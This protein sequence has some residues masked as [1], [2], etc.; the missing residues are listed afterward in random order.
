MFFL[1]VRS[2]DELGEVVA[3]KGLPTQ[4]VTIDFESFFDCQPSEVA[5]SCV[6]LMPDGSHQN[7]D[8]FH[9][10]LAPRF[11]PHTL[12]EKESGSVGHVFRSVTGIPCKPADPSARSDWDVLFREILAFVE[13]HD[14]LGV[15]F[16]KACQ[17]EAR[18]LHFLA[19]AAGFGVNE[20]VLPLLGEC[21]DLLELLLKR[22]LCANSFNIFVKEMPFELEA[23][24][25]FHVRLN[26]VRAER[27]QEAFHCALQDARTFGEM[28]LRVRQDPARLSEID[29]AEVEK[30]RLV[31]E[32]RRLKAEEERLLPGLEWGAFRCRTSGT[33]K[34]AIGRSP[35]TAEEARQ[36]ETE[37][38]ITMVVTAD[39][40]VDLLLH[41]DVGIRQVCSFICLLVSE[42]DCGEKVRAFETIEELDVERKVGNYVEKLCCS[43]EEKAGVA[44]ASER[45]ERV[46]VSVCARRAARA[47]FVLGPET[48]K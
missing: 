33:M 9:A 7:V 21:Q 41:T 48:G 5:L 8:V 31:E 24:C 35:R 20:V 4:F 25:P 34:L 47:R 10:L 12:S 2:R 32:A 13:K 1:V 43:K 23:C 27:R 30:A 14:K 17:L 15:L 28:V 45:G 37:L 22:P 18:S 39:A 16:C 11:N 38:G 46:R 6:A 42:V 29:A 19:A 40:D 3:A 26:R 44:A 36:L